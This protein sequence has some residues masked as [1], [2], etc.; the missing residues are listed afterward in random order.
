MDSIGSH[1]QCI[2]IIRCTQLYIT[3]KL[4]WVLRPKKPRGLYNRGN[5]GS[6]VGPE[7]LIRGRQPLGCLKMYQLSLILT[8][9]GEGSQWRIKDFLEEGP[10]TSKIVLFCNFFAKNDMRMKKFE[11]SLPPPP[12][13]LESFLIPNNCVFF[14]FG[15]GIS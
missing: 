1:F 2:V 11:A 9:P 12:P 7:F 14:Y 10:P 13:N 5:R 6:V 15:F 3:G 8:G 4:E